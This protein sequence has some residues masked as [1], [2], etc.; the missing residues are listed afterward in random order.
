MAGGVVEWH[1]RQIL[2]E[3]CGC[4]QPVAKPAGLQNTPW[5][6]RLVSYCETLV[7]KFARIF[8]LLFFFSATLGD[9]GK[10]GMS[11]YQRLD[12]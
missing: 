10:Y 2:K 7:N 4:V 12:K 11:D 1:R 5:Q 3:M 8:S 6:K 9:V